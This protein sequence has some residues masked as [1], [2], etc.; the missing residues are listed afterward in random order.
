MYVFVDE[1]KRKR[2]RSGDNAMN[3]L[4]R[5]LQKHEQMRK[6]NEICKLTDVYICMYPYTCSI[7]I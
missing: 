6:F 2:L 3:I 4:R 5:E 7:P 1:I